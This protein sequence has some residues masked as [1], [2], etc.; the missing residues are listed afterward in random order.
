MSTTT[1]TQPKASRRERQK[2]ETRRDLARIA[3]ELAT[4]RGLAD[5]RVPE[6]AAAAGVSTRTFNNY[7][8]SKEAA[9]AWPAMLRFTRMAELLRARPAGEPLGEALVAT[10]GELY[11]SRPRTATATSWMSK[12]RVLAATEPA[13][14]AEYLRLSDAGEQMLAGAIAE[15]AGVGEN[16]LRP[17]VLAAMVVG[18]ERAAIRHWMNNTDRKAP[19]VETVE[20]AL[21]EAL[22]EVVK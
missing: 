11:E 21:R 5:V 6:I 3:L 1:D 15:R 4:E 9:I 16:E 13:V 14:R 19:L 22:K 10:V 2:D 7:F 17:K 12:F 18:A 20:A 8:P